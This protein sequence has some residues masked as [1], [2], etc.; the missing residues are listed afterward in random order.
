MKHNKLVQLMLLLT[1]YAQVLHSLKIDWGDSSSKFFLSGLEISNNEDNG[2]D[3]E[4]LIPETSNNNGDATEL[5]GTGVDGIFTI[6]ENMNDAIP[7]AVP[8]PTPPPT[9][10][11]SK[12]KMTLLSLLLPPTGVKQGV[13]V[14]EKTKKK[15]CQDIADT[16]NNRWNA[17]RN[18]RFN[19]QGDNLND[20]LKD[21]GLLVNMCQQQPFGYPDIELPCFVNYD[22]NDDGSSD[23][24]HF[25]AS[26]IG[27]GSGEI[28]ELISTNVINPFLVNNPVKSRIG[29][30]LDPTMVDI[31]CSYPINANPKDR[32]KNGCGP[33]KNDYIF[34]SHSN[35]HLST[36]Q[37][38]RMLVDYNKT[39]AQQNGWSIDK[40]WE[41][42]SL[43]SESLWK[44]VSCDEMYNYYHT[45]MSKK[46]SVRNSTSLY[47]KNFSS[48]EACEYAIISNPYGIINDTISISS[49][50]QRMYWEYEGLFESDNNHDND[51]P[52]CVVDNKSGI[53]DEYVKHWYQWSGA[54]SWSNSNFQSM[55]DSQLNIVKNQM[56]AGG[57]ESDMDQEHNYWS[58]EIILDAS[59]Q[60]PKAALA[61]LLLLPKEDK[62][63][64]INSKEVQQQLDNGN[65][66]NNS[67]NKN[68][69][70]YNHENKKQE[71]NEFLYYSYAADQLVEKHYNNTIP[72]I[73][74]NESKEAALNGS[75]FSCP[76]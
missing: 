15:N 71:P 18:A 76:N 4:N 46:N 49:T 75:M 25:I 59:A 45:K 28:N 16:L 67:A 34:G 13:E 64:N 65:L 33:I 1:C 69:S 31:K 68:G 32:D 42:L 7:A 5:K 11:P 37:K 35:K 70:Y 40:W 55:I 57:K 73:L 26:W 74:V 48:I 24:D 22:D 39:I 10:K 17:A 58:N 29:I 21:H 9:P 12:T 43:Q 44:N 14:K 66:N 36:R 30:A 8:P 63:N 41:P 72:V 56:S 38:Y 20:W 62:D 60:N 52:P 19:D 50:I 23:S 53:N 54:C 6:I 2:E 47:P 27:G 3:S 51:H 61:V